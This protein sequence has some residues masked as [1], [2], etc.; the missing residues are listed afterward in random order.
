MAGRGGHPAGSTRGRGDGPYV[1]GAPRG[2]GLGLPKAGGAGSPLANTG[3]LETPQNSH[4]DHRKSRGLTFP[5]P[6]ARPARRGASVWQRQGRGA[7]PA[8]SRGPRVPGRGR[9]G[10]SGAAG[11]TCAGARGARRPLASRRRRLAVSRFHSGRVLPRCRTRL[12]A[13]PLATSVP[14]DC[15]AHAPAAPSPPPSRQFLPRH[16]TPAV[17]CRGP[18]VQGHASCRTR[19]L[20]AGRLALA[21]THASAPARDTQVRKLGL[22]ETA[23]HP[24]TE[25]PARQG[26]GGPWGARPG[27][28]AGDHANALSGHM[29]VTGSPS[30]VLC[31]PWEARSP[32]A[33]SVLLPEGGEGRCAP[34]GAPRS[35]D[36]EQLPRG[37]LRGTPSPPS[38]PPP[39]SIQT[40][41]GTWDIRE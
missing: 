38:R 4:G 22:T 33:K 36:E 11:P 31:T 34:T 26:A 39:A 35:G 10:G 16:P 7:G 6:G 23:Q 15:G 41:V 8:P 12:P 3:Q 20:L 1:A 32:S 29:K 19:P 40:S 28:D 13:A 14:G 2:A 25:Q 30:H 18:S 9:S 37:A 5:S 24:P 27:G 21:R 17:T